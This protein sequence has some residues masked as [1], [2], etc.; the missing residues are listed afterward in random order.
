MQPNDITF[1]AVFRMTF[2]LG[3][4]PLPC[5]M[6]QNRILKPVIFYALGA[7]KMMVTSALSKCWQRRALRLIR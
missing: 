3:V 5:A 4:K 2:W 1:F 7:M 6:T